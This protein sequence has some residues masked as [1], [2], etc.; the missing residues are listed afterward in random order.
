[1]KIGIVGGS[2]QERSLPFDAQRSVNLYPVVDSKGGAEFASMYGTAGLSLFGVAGSSGVTR[3]LFSASNGRAFSVV[4]SKVYEVFADGT[5]AERGSLDNSSGNVSIAENGFELAICDGVRLYIFTYS[6]NTFAKVTDADLPSAETVTFIDGYFVVNQNN[7][8]TFYISGQY[9]GT[10]WNALDFAT[11]E[12]SPDSLK[13][14]FGAIGQLWLLGN[15]TTEIWYNSGSSDF[16]FERISGGKI[17]VGVEA[18]HSVVDLDSSIFWLGRDKKGSGIVYRT[19]GFNAARISTHPIEEI[20][21]NASSRS[22]IRAFTYQENGHI[23]YVLTGGGLPTTLVYDIETGEWHERAFLNSFGDYEQHLGCCYMNAFGLNLVG[24]RR[25]GNIYEMSEDYY[26]DNGSPILRERIYTHLLDEDNRISYNRLV[27]GFE[28]GVGLQSGQGENPKVTLQLSKDGART[29]SGGY[30]TSI[31]KVGEYNNKAVFRRLG[32]AE[33]ITFRIK[34]SEPV[35][36]AITGS[37][38]S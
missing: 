19:S 31:G 35:K 15:E 20:I 3:A 25:N 26:T 23:F 37:Y 34:I 7:A 13:R 8:G 17:D 30:T 22:D 5:S 12:S 1:M 32:M 28:T 4:G 36:I 2:Y 29:W 38:L 24:D 6:T 33:K 18:P 10:S 11:A 21:Q 14:V 27:I 9:D 16:P